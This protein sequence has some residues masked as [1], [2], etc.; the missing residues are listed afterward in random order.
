MARDYVTYDEIEDVLSST[1]L[2]RLVAPK[3][4][5]EPALW[6]WAV[7]AAQNGL[8]GAIV[9]ALHDGVG[10]SVLTEKSARDLLRWHRAPHRDAYPKGLKLADFWTLVRRFCRQNPAAKERVNRRQI[11]DIHKL[12]AHFRNGFE[13]FQ[14][15]TWSI[16]KV[17]LPRTILTAIE[18]IEIA[19]AGR[20]IERRLTGNRTRRLKKNLAEARASILAVSGSH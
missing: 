10:A 20:T 13:H 3:L 18:F 7:I 8:Q 1:D 19:M 2:L 15:Q 6:K 4:K 11:R 17:G 16:E 9:C 14:P 12:H 5:K